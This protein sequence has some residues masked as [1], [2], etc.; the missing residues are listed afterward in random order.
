MERV[1]QHRRTILKTGA[2]ALLGVATGSSAAAQARDPVSALLRML[3]LL[4]TPAPPPPQP[5]KPVDVAGIVA[6]MTVLENQVSALG[7]KPTPLSL[8][9]AA[10]PTAPT[11]VNA[12]DL[13]AAGVPRLVSIIERTEASNVE[14]GDRAGELLADVNATQH[15]IPEA[16]DEKRVPSRARDFAGLKDEYAALFASAALRPERGDLAR[17]HVT[18]LRQFRRRYEAVTRATDVPWYFIG[19]IHGLEASYNFRAHLHNGDAPLSQ[20]TRQVPAGR[21]KA[22]TAPYDWEASAVDALKLMGFAGAT[23]WS[24]ERTLYRLEAYNGFGYR[25]L[26]VPTPYLW[27]F[28]NHYEAGKFV[29]DGSF[30]ARARSQQCG[31]A[32][33]LKLLT[34]AG[35][36][37]WA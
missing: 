36:V 8:E 9:P 21:P 5:G 3:G 24:L 6:A 26:G 12:D 34:E 33:T 7:L 35:E 14:L 16:F 4:K 18:A 11:P 13:Y 27:S 2:A 32:T 28:S 25:R 31:A 23:D 37:V 29:A 15:V 17:W 30:N 22:W 1:R 19:L 10:D 20:R